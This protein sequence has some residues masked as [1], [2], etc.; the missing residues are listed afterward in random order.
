MIRGRKA[1]GW[2]VVAEANLD[3]YRRRFVGNYVILADGTDASKIKQGFG[4]MRVQG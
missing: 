1:A 2:Q 3:A 4:P